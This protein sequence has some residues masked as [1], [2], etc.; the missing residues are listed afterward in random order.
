MSYYSPTET[1]TVD[2]VWF[3]FTVELDAELL[4]SLL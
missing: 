3:F 4:A 2:P 1:G